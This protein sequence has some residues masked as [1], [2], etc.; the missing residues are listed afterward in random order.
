MAKRII[1]GGLLGGILVFNWGYVAHMV[2]PLGEMGVPH[3]ARRGDGDRRDPE[4]DQGAGVLPLP[5]H[6][7]VRAGRP[8]PRC[9]PGRRRRSKGRSAS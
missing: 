1:L 2:L 3:T 5:G 7:H 9:K 6:G 4:H 8:N